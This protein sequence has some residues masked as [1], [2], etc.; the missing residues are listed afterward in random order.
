MGASSVGFVDRNAHGTLLNVIAAMAII[1]EASL[2]IAWV[3]P[4]AVPKVN[5]NINLGSGLLAGGP[6]LRPIITPT[7]VPVITDTPAPTK[8]AKPSSTPP[9]CSFDDIPATHGQ[10]TDW[11]STLLDTSYML[12]STYVPPDLVQVSTGGVE[13]SGQLRSF[14][15]PDLK[16]MV[17]AAANAGIPLIVASA[18]R[19]YTDQEATYQ[20]IEKN[21]G[22]DYAQKAAARPGHSEHQLGTT[23]DFTGGEAWLQAH[24]YEFGFIQ[25]YPQAFSPDMTC[26]QPEPWHYRY[27]GRERSLAIH[28][29]G[30]T[31]REWLWAYAK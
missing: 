24:G 28:N 18:Y 30:L 27:F 3:N 1:V 15:L 25:S 8:V 2:A 26:Y 11:A 5:F 10:L 21:Y 16:A 6:T 13:G 19:S 14:V 22:Q 4:S 31:S 12:S 20:D 9:P 7:L 23:I 17:D 29:S